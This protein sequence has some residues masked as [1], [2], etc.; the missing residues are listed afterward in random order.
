MN[1]TKFNRRTERMRR[2]EEIRQ[3][4]LRRRPKQK[5][6]VAMADNP[7]NQSDLKRI[8][9]ESSGPE[10]FAEKVRRMAPLGI[11]LQIEIDGRTYRGIPGFTSVGYEGRPPRDERIELRERL[12]QAHAKIEEQ[13]K[14]LESITDGALLMGT[15]ISLSEEAGKAGKLKGSVAVGNQVVSCNIPAGAVPGDR[16]RVIPKSSQPLDIAKGEKTDFG[17]VCTVAR[18]IDD[19]LEVTHGT[20]TRTV[21]RGNVTAIAGDRIVVD[22][23]F[24]VALRNIG[25]ADQTYLFESTDGI[26]WDS[27]GGLEDAKEALREAI[28]YPITHA[29]LFAFYGKSPSKGVLLHG[30]SGCGKTMLGKAAAS[31]LSARGASGGFIYVKGPEILS[32]WVGEAEAT[33]RS[34]FAM[35]RAYHTRTGQAA[36]IFIDEAEAV[37]GSRNTAGFRG[38]IQSTLVPA[39][40]AEM[41]GLTASGAFVMLATNLPDSLDSAIVRDGRIDRKIQ[42]TRP[43]REVVADI[44]RLSAR[45]VPT[46]ID[47]VEVLCREVFDRPKTVLNGHVGELKFELM[48]SELAS[49]A[50]ASGLVRRAVEHAMRRDRARGGDPSGVNEDDAIA[51]VVDAAREMRHLDWQAEIM[52]KLGDAARTH[53]VHKQA[54]ASGQVP[55]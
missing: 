44:L 17:E 55:N 33:I 24:H 5:E 19:L 27:I 34:L 6:K 46:S 16:V 18:A 2:K 39:F 31:A 28:E 30:P 23:G 4:E 14:F 26:T 1:T 53:V 3:E 47:L 52:A 12:Q 32:S 40:L 9:M 48:L 21:A 8:L 36:V 10:D 42:V 38:G 11:D 50:L 22:P 49:G 43:G 7:L 15:V 37:L 20:G 45:G 41:D 29:D 35:A 25:P 51:A 13:D 54:Q